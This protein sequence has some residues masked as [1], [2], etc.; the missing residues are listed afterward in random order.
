MASHRK[1][2]QHPL[3]GATART[4]AGLAL[5]G[6]ATA[7]VLDGSAQAAPHP[8]PSQLRTRIDR[9]Y[10][11]AE[12]ATE[13]YNGAKEKADRA[14]STLEGLQ[15][16]AARRTA[17]LNTARNALGSV[18]TAQYREGSLPTS[19]RLLMSASPEQ[20]L[21][22]A[23]MSDRAG[24]RR[25]IAVTRYRDELRDVEQVRTSAGGRLA[26]LRR[27][28]ATLARH[29]RA[30]ESKLTEA[31]KILER[32]PEE[33]RAAVARGDAAP[34][35]APAGGVTSAVPAALHTGG[36]VV[37]G[38]AQAPTQ[39]AARA[40]AYA[41]SALGKPYVWG[42]TGP[43]A[44][45]C[46]GLTQAAWRAAGVSL[47]RT[48]Y[49]Q[50]NAGRRISRGALA[51]GDLVFF[52]SGVSHVGIYVGGGRMIHAPHPGAPVRIAPVDEMPFA[53][54]SRPA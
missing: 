31:R 25:S 42:A 32:L 12:A 11:E 21:E 18:A 24:V 46:S 14:E 43:S 9:Y 44:F 23:S 7:T 2:R 22:R 1:P 40:V 19:V 10:Q 54:A 28:K 49:T 34:Q 36:S 27:E 41:Y 5:A 30:V 45:D 6:A 3:T 50:I 38:A 52:Y 13:R 47:P 17:R 53:G 33:H 15:D 4:A 37:G 51:P 20:Y 48:T 26:E 16:E 8:T 39:R 29:K 35:A